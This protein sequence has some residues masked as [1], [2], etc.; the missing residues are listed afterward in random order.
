MSDEKDKIVEVCSKC[1][2][3]SC[4][5][6]EFMCFE[7]RDAG[8]VL[9]P[10]SELTKLALEHP[11]NWSDEKL[12]AVCGSAAPNGYVKKEIP[13]KTPNQM[14]HEM[15]IELNKFTKKCVDLRERY[16]YNPTTITIEYEEKARELIDAF[17]SH[18]QDGENTKIS[19]I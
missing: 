4:W 3:A 1:L 5:H 9:K 6:G 8:T 16:A 18:W 12:L 13:E 2:Q 17:T 11:D 10:V 19:G 15:Y 7:S 14:V